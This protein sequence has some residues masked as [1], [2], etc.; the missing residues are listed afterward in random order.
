MV[1]CGKVSVT[2]DTDYSYST[3]RAFFL[4]NTQD[5]VPIRISTKIDGILESNEIIEV[6]AVLPEERGDCRAQVIIVD[7]SKLLS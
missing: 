5:N 4:N 1:S 3:R 2:D 7:D 6:I